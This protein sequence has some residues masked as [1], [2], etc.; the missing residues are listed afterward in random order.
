MH[1]LRAMVYS[2][3]FGFQGGIASRPEGQ[4]GY[5]VKEWYMNKKTSFTGISGAITLVFV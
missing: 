5:Y 1:L 3:G 4:S 2:I